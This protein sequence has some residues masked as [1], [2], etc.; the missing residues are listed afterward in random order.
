MD[1]I[2]V[3]AF[4]TLAETLSF[5]KA[6]EDLFKNQSVL[7][8]QISALE[9]E[10]GVTLFKRHTRSV[11]LTPAGKVFQDGLKK[12]VVDFES[13]LGRVRAAQMGV[14]GEIRICSISG[15]LIGDALGP[16]IK[17]FELAY[18]HIQITLIAKTINE[19][20]RM[21]SAIEIDFVFARSRD[22]DYITNINSYKLRDVPNSMVIPTN[23]PMASRS[24][25][26]LVLSDFRQDTFLVAEELSGVRTTTEKLCRAAGFEPK[27]R[28]APNLS[29]IMFWLEMGE[30]IAAMNDS[31][32]FRNNPK[33]KFLH[34]PDMGTSDESIIWS[35][36]ND[37]PCRELFSEFAMKFNMERQ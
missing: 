20:R 12:I 9:K 14:E 11:S 19:M 36:Q 26:S 8:R 3:T 16:L 32:T 28:M 7:S 31:H 22:F 34:L 23:H 29:T 30:G 6:A 25:E 17:A 15:M 5:T 24:G 18:P 37:N 4:I 27:I 33:L 35:S 13:L 21:L 10:L 1:D 2:K